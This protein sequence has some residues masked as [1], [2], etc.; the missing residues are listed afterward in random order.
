[1][2]RFVPK[3]FLGCIVIKHRGESRFVGQVRSWWVVIAGRGHSY[4]PYGRG[5]NARAYARS[6][7]M[8]RM[9]CNSRSQIGSDRVLQTAI[10]IAFQCLGRT[11]NPDL[12][13]CVK[14]EQSEKAP[15][16]VNTAGPSGQNEGTGLDKRERSESAVE[17]IER[18][19]Y[20]LR[21]GCDLECISASYPRARLLM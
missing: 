13:R 11:C 4:Y 18:Y 6:R 3:L 7:R 21:P 10:F 15:I 14:I 2:A 1:M 12:S 9:R 17:V 19:L 16:M 5:L 20:S 8:I